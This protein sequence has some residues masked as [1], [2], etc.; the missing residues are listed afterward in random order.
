MKRMLLESVWA[1]ARSYLKTPE[2]LISN[3]AWRFP[4]TVSNLELVFVVGAPRSGTT[5]LQNVLES[6]SRYFSIDGETGMFSWQ[7]IF[8][9]SRKHFGL[10]HE[11]LQPIIKQ[12]KD[13]VDFFD[14]CVSSLPGSKEGLIFIEKPPQHVLH[15][16]FL[17]K[18]FPS[19]KFIHIVRD[20][21]DCYC[22][23]KSHR[24]IPQ[25]KS[26][27]AFA[28]YWK[29]CVGV[30]LSFSNN[31]SIYT[32]RYENF[33]KEPEKELALLMSFLGDA[34]EEQQLNPQFYGNDRRSS[35]RE[36]SQLKEKITDSSVQRWAKDMSME[37]IAIFNEIAGKELKAFGYAI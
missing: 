13:V 34:Q 16:T 21:R 12:S 32:V 9:G 28:A 35:Q 11:K 29:K 22:S 36:F 24:H 5:L 30:P 8:D 33:V 15:M 2:Y 19:A 3:V 7:N 27:N 26:A 31:S 37:D 1:L 14:Q 10:T 20:G 4:R 6:H 17:R 18:H 25:N 23:S